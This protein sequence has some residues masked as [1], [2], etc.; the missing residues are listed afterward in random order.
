MHSQIHRLSRDAVEPAVAVGGGVD[1]PSAPSR[2]LC[3]IA[4]CIADDFPAKGKAYRDLTAE[5]WSELRSI[6]AE[7]HYALNWLCGRA[8]KNK[9]DETPTDT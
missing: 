6:T 5:E 2:A 4:P 8:P 7:R 1:R 9:W 3:T